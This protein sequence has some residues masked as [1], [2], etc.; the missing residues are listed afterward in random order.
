MLINEILNFILYGSFFISIIYVSLYAINK[1]YDTVNT[2]SYKKSNVEKVKEFA[3]YLAFLHYHMDRAYDIVH[4]DQ[5]LVYSIEGVKLDEDKLEYAIKK[6]TKI[7]IDFMGPIMS[8]E[9]VDLYGNEETLLLNIS[10]YFSTKYED[11]AIRDDSL[12]DIMGTNENDIPD[13]VKQLFSN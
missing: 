4:K 1:I 11:D 5:V 6:F 8:Q 9:L 7:T 13:N 12:K 3:A 10:E 2:I